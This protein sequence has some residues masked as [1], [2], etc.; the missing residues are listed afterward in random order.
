MPGRQRWAGDC[1]LEKMEDGLGTRDT[2]TRRLREVGADRYHHKHPFHL[3][4]N[5]GRLAPEAIRCW[6]RNRFY[7]QR[8]IPVKDAAI[9]SNCPLREVRRLWIHRI[10]D[11]DGVIPWAAES[12]VLSGE[13]S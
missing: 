2:F 5:D 7:Y 13:R 3:A 11:H 4:M 9:L 10:L 8:N 12:V 6:V 1:N